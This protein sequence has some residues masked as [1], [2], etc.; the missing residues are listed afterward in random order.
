MKNWKRKIALAVGL[1]VASMAGASARAEDKPSVIRIGFPG[2]GVGNRPVNGGS[3]LASAH[4]RG[5]FEE[6]FKKDGIEIKWSF[7]RGAGPAVNE[8]YA[9]GLLDF[10]TLGDL[11]SVI[12]RSSGLHYRLLAASNVRGNIYVNVPADSSAQ[13][14][15]DLRGKRIAV[16]KGT[17]THLAGLKVLEKF[18]LTDKDVKLVNMDTNAAQLALATRDIDATFAGSDSLRIRDQG[19]SRVIY[20]T[21][22]QDP[23]TTSNSGFLGSEEFI[24]KY[25]E[26]TKRV[27]KLYVQSSKWIAEVPPTQLF[28]LWTKSGTTFSSYREDLAGEDIKYRYSPL[29]DPYIEARYN[30]QIA[31]SK[32]LGLT[33]NQ[34]SFKEWAEPKYLQAVLKELGLENYWQPRGQNGKPL[35]PEPKAATAPA[36]ASATSLAAK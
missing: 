20:T 22:G 35:K 11:P 24:K 29:I 25:P 32:R 31:E 5:L 15:K 6:E 18:G 16:N 21:R 36:P 2:V 7:L 3:A 10:S 28:Q 27:L 33:R 30:L 13:S 26:L 8:L 9:N 34:F 4:L 23:S 12:G 17:A 19:I 14:V 1:L